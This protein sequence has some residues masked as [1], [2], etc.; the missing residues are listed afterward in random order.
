MKHFSNLI[1]NLQLGNSGCLGA[2]SWKTIGVFFLA[3]QLEMN[4]K[5]HLFKITDINDLLRM[6]SSTYTSFMKHKNNEYN[7]RRDKI[8]NICQTIENKNLKKKDVKSLYTPINSSFV[9]DHNHQLAYCQIP[10]V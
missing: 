1:F 4:I 3:K 5:N 2:M 9:Y 8:K 7:Q 10:K 6:D